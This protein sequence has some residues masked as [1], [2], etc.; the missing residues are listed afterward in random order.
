MA[1]IKDIA[2]RTGLSRSTVSRC[3]SGRG[4]V[5]AEARTAIEEAAR[6]LDYQPNSAAVSL[7]RGR[8]ARIAVFVPTTAHSYYATFISGVGEGAR[9]HGYD[10]LV[11]QQTDDQA[12]LEAQ[13]REIKHT[14]LADGAILASTIAEEAGKE[15]AALGFPL[16]AC[17]QVLHR[18]RISSVYMDH[19]RSTIDVLE[20]L[21]ARG[22]RSIY[23][24][25][26]DDGHASNL[27]REKAAEEFL[28]RRLA[29]G[30][31]IRITCVVENE[32]DSVSAGVALGKR[33]FEL[34]KVPD[35]V[36]TGSDQLAAGLLL[37]A[38]GAR[39]AVPGELAIVGFDDQSLSEALGLTTVYQPT[40]KMGRKA[41]ELLHKLIETEASGGRAPVERYRVMHT[42]RARATS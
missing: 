11:R 6:E 32:D 30:M 37:F 17:D 25:I 38:G 5:S 10:L 7:R 26:A 1:T 8:S 42:L 39:I 15:V 21:V 36:F 12:P 13:L 16:V 29:E 20:H 33:L 28:Q 23:V 31:R 4:Y 27:Y 9:R 41:A 24:V 3:L 18:E 2:A 14:R 22:R 34:D 19:Y 40:R 35:A